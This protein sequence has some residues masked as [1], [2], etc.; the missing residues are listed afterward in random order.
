M[1]RFLTCLRK[2]HRTFP[3]L[4]SS[5][6]IGAAHA[7]KTNSTDGAGFFV[8]A[9]ETK[10]EEREVLPKGGSG[11]VL[12]YSQSGTIST[13]RF[14]IHTISTKTITKPVCVRVFLTGQL[15]SCLWT[16]LADN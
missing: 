1:F 13:R 12:N 3:Q 16:D 10:E 5:Y 11:A 8:I 6:L 2:G 7:S 4:N 9:E 15:L 14:K